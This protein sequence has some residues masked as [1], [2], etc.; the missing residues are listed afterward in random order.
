MPEQIVQENDTIV[1]ISSSTREKFILRIIDKSQK[2]QGLGVYNPIK[3]VKKIYGGMVT[4]G[5]NSYWIL[6]PNTLDHIDT[7]R[8]KAQI[9]I[10]KDAALLSMFC[11]IKPGSIIVEGGL[12]SG[13]LSIILLSLIGPN[14]KVITYET[15]SEF[16]K[17]GSE[18]IIKAGLEHLWVLKLQDITKG[19]SEKKVDAVILDIPE[20]WNAVGTAHAALRSG[21]IFA[22]YLPTMN[23]VEKFVNALKEEP[24][25]EIHSFETLF[26]ELEVKA[27][28]TRPSFEMLGHTGYITVARKVLN[29]SH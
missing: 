19:I 27:G 21:G 1:L 16:A 4:L 11:N 3:L 28:A 8:R 22:S 2:I 25:I 14:G 9:I 23:Q 7:L 26:R 6:P 15:R 12:G 10:P 5:S 20:P 13:A 29:K 24:F 18:N 17:V